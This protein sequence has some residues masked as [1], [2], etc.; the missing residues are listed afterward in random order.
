MN[1]KVYNGLQEA[2]CCITELITGISGTVLPKEEQSRYHEEIF[3]AIDEASKMLEAK[4]MTQDEIQQVRRALLIAEMFFAA[5]P[6]TKSAT[7]NPLGRIIREAIETCE[8]NL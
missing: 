8:K 7:I 5:V 3:D 4:T 1:Y 6:A 2:K